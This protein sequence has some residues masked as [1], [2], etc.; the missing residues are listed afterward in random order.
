MEDAFRFIDDRN[1]LASKIEG[2]E[3]IDIRDYPVDAVREALINAVVHREYSFSD[4]TLVKMFD[5][6]MQ[7]VNLGGLPDGIELQDIAAGVSRLRN[8]KL[9]GVFFRLKLIEAYGT[10]I[11]KIRSAYRYD[12]KRPQISFSKGAFTI[13][14]P[15]RSYKDAL[16]NGEDTARSGLRGTGEPFEVSGEGASSLWLRSRTAAG[17][18]SPR[19]ALR[20]EGGSKRALASFDL[21]D[22]ERT[23][24]FIEVEGEATRKQIEELL[25]VGQT[26]AGKVLRGLAEDGVIVQ[27]GRGPS[28]RYRLAG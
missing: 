1:N 2:L 14:L 13:A 10:G 6:Q 12:V 7:I 15:N 25:G 3:R 8:P 5:D 20:E 28:T 11:A 21:S 19:N 4:A 23:V 17:E 9:A 27:E 18:P 22:I 16:S 26:T 24:R